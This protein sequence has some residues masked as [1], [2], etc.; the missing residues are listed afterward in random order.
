[1]ARVPD[2]GADRGQHVLDPVVQLRVQNIAMLLGLL[3]LGE[4]DID[5]DDALGAAVAAIGNKIARFDP[6]Y[7]TVAPNNAILRFVCAAPLVQEIG[8][9]SCRE[10]VCSW[11][12]A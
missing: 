3:A 11:L 7:L 8:R 6:A 2:N 9:A 1:M 10:R 4:V 12:V 5:T